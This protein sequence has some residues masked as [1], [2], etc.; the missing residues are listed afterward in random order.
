METRLVELIQT[1]FKT[2]EAWDEMGHMALCAPEMRYCGSISGIRSGELLD[3]RGIFHGARKHL[4]I[5]QVRPLRAFGAWPEV[6]VIAEIHFAEPINNLNSVE[7]IWRFVFREDGLI[8][9]L[10]IIWSPQGSYVF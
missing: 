3:Y 2:H 8:Q 10:S 4:K 5:H 7:G 6:A 9:E 1:F